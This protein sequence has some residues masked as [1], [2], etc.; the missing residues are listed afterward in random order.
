MNGI[1]LE[2]KNELT[3]KNN[4]EYSTENGGFNGLIITFDECNEAVYPK[5]C[6]NPDE[7]H[8]FLGKNK[9]VIDT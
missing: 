1:C 8:E 4:W 9:I 2:N 3:L 6:K 7:I 5:L